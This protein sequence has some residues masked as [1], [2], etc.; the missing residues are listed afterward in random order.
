L[1]AELNEVARFYR[2]GASGL[3]QLGPIDILVTN[4]QLEGKELE[5][6]MLWRC[7]A[8]GE[9]AEFDRPADQHQD[10]YLCRCRSCDA[11]IG[12]WGVQRNVAHWL[13]LEQ[14]RYG[15]QPRRPT[16]D[17]PAVPSTAEA[18]IASMVSETIPGGRLGR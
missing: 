4:V 17:G 11:E 8:C 3:D 6:N 7:L 14:A 10:D 5:F 18:R 15:D 9:T 16:T 12:P 1:P 13:A 2:I